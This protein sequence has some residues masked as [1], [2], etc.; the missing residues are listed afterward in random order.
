MYLIEKLTFELITV[1]QIFIESH[2]E[3]LNLFHKHLKFLHK[4]EKNCLNT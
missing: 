4:D 2:Q 1:Q 3:L